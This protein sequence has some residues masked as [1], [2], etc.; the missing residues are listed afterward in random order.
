MGE[1]LTAGDICTRDVSFAL[2]TTDLA[3]AARLMREHHA[4]ALVVVD[5]KQGERV[6]EG[7]LT[8]RDIVVAVVAPGLDPA[9]LSVGDVMGAELVTAPEDES[10]IDL[11]RSMRDHG[12]RRIPVVG[13]HKELI[14]MVTMDDVLEVLSQ[15]LELLVATIGNE[16]RRERRLRT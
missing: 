11:M 14:G 16:Q 5:E 4:G 2:R 7:V 3:M 12:V 10:L 9:K 6:V 1:R 13:A 8:D 15:E